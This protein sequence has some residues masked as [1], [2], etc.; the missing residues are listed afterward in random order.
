MAIFHNFLYVY[1]FTRPGIIKM[2]AMKKKICHPLI[3]IHWG[4]C[5][6]LQAAGARR[7]DCNPKGDQD[8]RAGLGELWKDV[9]FFFKKRNLG[10][11]TDES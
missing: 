10:W 9:I 6:R 3:A 1:R 11:E 7:S 4:I 8:L 2:V 5:A